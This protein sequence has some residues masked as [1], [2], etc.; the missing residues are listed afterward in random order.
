MGQQTISSVYLAKNT[1]DPIKISI[2]VGF[3]QLGTVKVK[4]GDNLIVGDISPIEDVQIGKNKELKRKEIRCSIDIIDIQP[5]TNKVGAE[6][7]L[8]GGRH[9]QQFTLE[10]ELAQGDPVMFYTL[11]ILII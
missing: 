6:I 8:K 2:K 7:T 3:A 10:N 5:A 4:L 11:K 9:D 1:D